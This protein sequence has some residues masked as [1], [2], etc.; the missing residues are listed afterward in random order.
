[1]QEVQKSVI[2]KETNDFIDAIEEKMLN[3]MVES[4]EFEV[5]DFPVKHTFTNGLYAREITMK[6]GARITSKIHLTEHQF[7]ISQGCAIVFDNGEEMLL[8]APYHGVTK[9]GTRRVLMIPEDAE[10]PCV[11]TT[12]HPNPNNENLEQI[13]GRIIEK[14]DNPLLTEQTKKEINY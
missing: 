9:K 8:E 6:Q 10:V 12:F 14:H 1:M 4:G 2:P 11:W 7:I 13:A 5:V 3:E